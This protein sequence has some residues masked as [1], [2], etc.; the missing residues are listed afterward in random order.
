MNGDYFV[1]L[2]EFDDVK[3]LNELISSTGGPSIYKATFG[4]FNF[5]Y[6]IEHSFLSVIATAD[7]E[8]NEMKGAGFA[9]S[10]DA[11]PALLSDGDLYPIVF[12]MLVNHFPATV[13]NFYL[14]LFNFLYYLPLIYS[15][16]YL[17][18]IS[19]H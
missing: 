5:S 15:Y 18:S 9:S 11:L 10:N 13:T 2:A 1:R 19:F 17:I 14:C 16:L 3:E 6:V 4:A 8:E 7:T 12:E